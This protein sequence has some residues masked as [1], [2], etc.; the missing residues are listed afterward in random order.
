MNFTE[1]FAFAMMI[2]PS[3]QAK[4]AYRS[5]G[6]LIGDDAQ[7]QDGMGNNNCYNGG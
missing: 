4:A 6:R 1:M 3:S 7:V 5:K 2:T